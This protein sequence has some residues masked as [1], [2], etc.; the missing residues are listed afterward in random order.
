MPSRVIEAKI[1][2]NG[3]FHSIMIIQMYLESRVTGIYRYQE[4]LDWLCEGIFEKLTSKSL[5]F[6]LYL[7]RSFQNVLRMWCE[8]SNS[9]SRHFTYLK[10]L[11]RI[12]TELGNPESISAS[13][14]LP[15]PIFSFIFYIFRPN[16]GKL[17]LPWRLA[18]SEELSENWTTI[19]ISNLFSTTST[20]FRVFFSPPN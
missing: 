13:P 2:A 3:G 19:L 1:V 7:W 20:P 15:I 5:Y 18:L 14:I 4:S 16:F 8:N 9:T 11:L 10:I 6:F 17:G 12:V